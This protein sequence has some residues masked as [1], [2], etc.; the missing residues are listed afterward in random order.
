ME[1]DKRHNRRI[2]ASKITKIEV[3]GKAYE[4]DTI[5]VSQSGALI[6][7][8]APLEVGSKVVWGD[9]K[10]GRVAGVV[11]RVT[12]DGYGIVFRPGQAAT[13]H[14]LKKITDGLLGPEGD[15]EG[16]KHDKK[17]EEPD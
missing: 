15:P 11:T 5:N 10:I 6:D 17:W 16:K 12:P 9:A 3:A 7:T 2:A 1:S 8:E 13:P 14:L 4:A